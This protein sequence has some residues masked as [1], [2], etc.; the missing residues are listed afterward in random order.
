MPRRIRAGA[1]RASRSPDC[2]AA[3]GVVT[4]VISAAEPTPT[5]AEPEDDP[6]PSTA[7]PRRGRVGPPEH[8]PEIAAA[9]SGRLVELDDG[10][11]LVGEIVGLTL[12]DR[13]DEAMRGFFDAYLSVCR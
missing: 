8:F 4:H 2:A 13:F 6:P 9:G 10:N 5:E 7:R 3:A 12:G 1:R 11:S